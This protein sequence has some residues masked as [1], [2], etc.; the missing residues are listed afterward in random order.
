MQENPKGAGTA[1]II[2]EKPK[3]FVSYEVGLIFD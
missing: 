3:G 1:E 2:R